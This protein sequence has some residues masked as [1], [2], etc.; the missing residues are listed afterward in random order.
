M[1]RYIEQTVTFQVKDNNYK[2][3]CKK[4]NG[5]SFCKYNLHEDDRYDVTEHLNIVQQI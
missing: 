3:L 1:Y 5:L 4:P 2:F